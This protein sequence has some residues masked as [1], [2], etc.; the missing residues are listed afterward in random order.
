MKKL[1]K[2]LFYGSDNFIIKWEP[3]IMRRISKIH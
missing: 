2:L 1:D 3:F